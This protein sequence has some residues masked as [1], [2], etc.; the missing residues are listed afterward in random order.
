ME[1]GLSIDSTYQAYLREGHL[2]GT[3]CTGCAEVYFPPRGICPACGSRALEWVEL[4]REG[5]LAAFT[6]IH[7][8]PASLAA[9]GFDRDHPYCVGIV[10]LENRM[11]ASARI[12]G[13]D[14]RHPET[15]AIGLPLVL[16]LPPAG[17]AANSHI[18]LAFKPVK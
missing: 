9:E 17:E 2:M 16:E 1:A 12:L 8:P 6:V 10:E 11:R 3:R 15:I 18:V 4:P 14:V 5:R 13:V 7:V